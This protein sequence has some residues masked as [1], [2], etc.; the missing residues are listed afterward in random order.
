MAMYESGSINQRCTNAILRIKSV[1]EVTGLSR[2]TI[3]AY[4]SDGKFPKARKLGVRAVGWL[5]EDVFQW[6]SEREVA[7]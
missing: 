1:M 6:L 3:Y 7:F 2:S 4:V 5:A